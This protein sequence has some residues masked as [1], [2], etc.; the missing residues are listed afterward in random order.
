MVGSNRGPHASSRSEY[1]RPYKLDRWRHIRNRRERLG[2]LSELMIKRIMQLCSDGVNT[3]TTT[4]DLYLFYCLFKFMKQLF[5]V[6]K[7][8]IKYFIHSVILLVYYL[9][10]FKRDYG[11]GFDHNSQEI[12]TSGKISR[13]GHQFSLQENK[14]HLK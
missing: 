2:R 1:S 11:T 13:Q 7:W 3:M 10:S 14:Q 5:K 4:T 6:A 8:I 12:F 9:G